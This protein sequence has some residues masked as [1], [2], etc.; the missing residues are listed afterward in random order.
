MAAGEKLEK[1]EKIVRGSKAAPINLPEPELTRLPPDKEKFDNLMTQQTN[2]ATDK[3]SSGIRVETS[4]PKTALVDD[5]N[6]LDTQVQRLQ[7]SPTKDIIAQ[8]QEVVDKMEQAK[9]KLAT[10][11]L[12]IQDSVQ[13]LMR[14]KLTHIDENL[15]IAFSKAG[16]EY[17]EKQV[18]VQANPVE[19]FLGLLTDGQNKLSTLGTE[20][21][22][23]HANKE[24]INP[25]NMLL[26]Q[27]KVGQ[28]QQELE[29]FSSLLNKSLES[30]KTIMNVQV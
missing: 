2:P 22:K 20:V 18:A 13:T 27:I 12:Q 15:R 5:I 10:P 28:I 16:L 23:W 17:K 8:A 4:V 21:Q 1:I 25:A 24:D 7:S 11:N 14:N 29:F 3:I 26:L 9:T 6:K 19:R 30:T